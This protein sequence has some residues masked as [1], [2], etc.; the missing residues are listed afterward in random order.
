MSA[1]HGP[2]IV[3]EPSMCAQPLLPQERDPLIHN[4]FQ[5]LLCIRMLCGNF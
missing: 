2:G 5:L 3:A 1:N 4:A